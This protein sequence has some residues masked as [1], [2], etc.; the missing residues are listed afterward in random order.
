MLAP[1]AAPLTP[2]EEAAL[3]AQQ[4]AVPQPDGYR[5]PDAYET[6][7]YV[8]PPAEGAIPASTTT[9]PEGQPIEAAPVQNPIAEPVVYDPSNTGAAPTTMGG[10]QTWDASSGYGAVE[11]SRA[12]PPASYTAP[13]PVPEPVAG[14]SAYYGG[15]TSAAPAAASPLNQPGVVTTTYPSQE[16]AGTTDARIFTGEGAGYTNR[17]GPAFQPTMPTAAPGSGYSPSSNPTS[18]RLYPAQEYQHESARGQGAFAPPSTESRSDIR[19]LP[20]QYVPPPPPASSSLGTPTLDWLQGADDVAGNL[21]DTDPARNREAVRNATPQ[22][23]TD[24]FGLFDSTSGGA[25]SL[26]PSVNDGIAAKTLDDEKAILKGV[27]DHLPPEGA[28]IPEELAIYAAASP[29]APILNAGRTVSDAARRLYETATPHLADLPVGAD[30]VARVATG[31]YDEGQ[32]DRSQPVGAIAD[33]AGQGAIDAYTARNSG[34]GES[35]INPRVPTPEDVVTV[36]NTP[37]PTVN[38]VDPGGNSLTAKALDAGNATGAA[39]LDARD[40]WRTTGETPSLPT[41]ADMQG[42]EVDALRAVISNPITPEP[43]KN[44]ARR[45]MGAEMARQAGSIPPPSLSLSGLGNPLDVVRGMVPEPSASA[46]EPLVAPSNGAML[47]STP[48][49]DR[50]TSAALPD[51]PPTTPR[52]GQSPSAGQSDFSGRGQRGEYTPPG[53]SDFSRRDVYPTQMSNRRVDLNGPWVP[54]PELSW[55]DQARGVATTAGDTVVDRARALRDADVAAKAGLIPES[56]PVWNV[57]PPP[58]PVI[59]APQQFDDA[60]SAAGAA[61]DAAVRRATGKIDMPGNIP[62]MY[63]PIGGGHETT[64]ASF[65]GYGDVG[66]AKPNA[67]ASNA[68]VAPAPTT[69]PDGTSVGNARESTFPDVELLLNAKGEPIGYIDENG[70]DVLPSS[71]TTQDAFNAAVM[72]VQE[73]KNAK[74]VIAEPAANSVPAGEAPVTAGAVPTGAALYPSA[75]P[76]S[77]GSSGSGKE[78]VDYG[79]SGGGGYRGG[80]NGSWDTFEQSSSRGRAGSFGDDFET[81][82]TADD[83]MDQAGGNRKRAEFLAKSANTRRRKK[84]GTSTSSGTGGFDPF[85][86]QNTPMRDSILAS[87]A[88]SK[89]AGKARKGR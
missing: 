31:P 23:V 73:A 25:P 9:Y 33:L 77:S 84:R 11:S 8:P 71:D 21:V 45:L 51:P 14:A 75:A 24:F 80:G 34:F 38:G 67:P 17:V 83:F 58:L 26:N 86:R 29:L 88:E 10:G 7:P 72:R 39:I 52:S 37:L 79:N 4:E 22:G 85:N 69:R 48:P 61:K 6:Q 20:G 36:M 54:E 15:E 19:T 28:P 3:L 70:N 16:G 60:V 2:E 87:I 53:T 1:T 40:R 13:V 42:M 74:G 5:P 55:Q 57:N 35:P 82:F 89:A 43:L 81:D 56:L 68:P 32:R 64:P 12:A 46:P 63:P 49:T 50:I 59:D 44:E 18:P 27:R 47:P 76:S 78:W 65:R 41:T 66:G 30:D 62:D